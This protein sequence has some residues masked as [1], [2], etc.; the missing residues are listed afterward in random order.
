[1]QSDLARR[2]RQDQLGKDGFD[3][4]MLPRKS[5][6]LFSLMKK[7]LEKQNKKIKQVKIRNRHKAEF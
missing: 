4:S 3:R 7:E 1:M 6:D 5:A 2:N